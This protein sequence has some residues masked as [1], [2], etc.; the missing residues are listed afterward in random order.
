[1]ADLN[2]RIAVLETALSDSI[3]YPEDALRAARIRQLVATASNRVNPLGKY[4]TCH[5]DSV[6]Q[7]NAAIDDAL[8]GK[9]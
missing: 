6:E 3:I 1:M 8:E 7:H 4:D 2:Q 5:F 9:Q